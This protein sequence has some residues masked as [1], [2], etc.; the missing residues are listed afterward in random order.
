MDSFVNELRLLA[1]TLPI[2]AITITAFRLAI[3][4][5]KRQ[6]WWDDFWAFMAALCLVIFVAAMELHFRDEGKLFAA[7]APATVALSFSRLLF[8]H[9]KDSTVL[10]VRFKLRSSQPSPYI[11]IRRL[12]H[13]FYAVNWCSKLSIL[14][15]TVRL[16]PPGT[17]RR[18]II[19]I[20]YAF[21]CAWL[22][23]FAQVFW[24]CENQPGWKDAP[25]PQCNLGKNVAIAQVITDVVTDAILVSAPLKLVWRVK[26]T[27]PRKIR[28]M[29]VFSSTAVAT[30]VSLYH[31]YAI[32][33]FGGFQE[34][35]AAVIQD[36]VT[37]IVV[38]LGVV[39]T[40]FMRISSVEEPNHGDTRPVQLIQ[41]RHSQRPQDQLTVNVDTS[42]TIYRNYQHVLDVLK[43]PEESVKPVFDGH[44]LMTKDGSTGYAAV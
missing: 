10:Y 31:A 8:I 34:A 15:S 7:H 2:F 27:R 14:V 6:L 28:I 30:A 22:V 24:T 26:L 35:R 36:G 3:R 40:F 11:W 18:S 4:A 43:F 5:H 12:D 39:L 23:L 17:F 9:N 44:D 25:D 19:Y 32:L 41:F 29:A 13:F 1:W 42:T 16:S 37:L 20:G 33:R 21:A 38:S